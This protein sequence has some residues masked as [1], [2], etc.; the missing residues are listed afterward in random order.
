MG[1]LSGPESWSSRGAYWEIQDTDAESFFSSYGTKAR[2]WEITNDRDERLPDAGEFRTIGTFPSRSREWSSG[3]R[4]CTN[5]LPALQRCWVLVRNFFLLLLQPYYY[6]S[7]CGRRGEYIIYLW[8]AESPHN[9]LIWQCNFQGVQ[10]GFLESC[11]GDTGPLDC[12]I[13]TQ[14]KPLWHF[15]NGSRRNASC[16]FV[17]SFWEHWTSAWTQPT[18]GWRALDNP[19]PRWCQWS[20]SSERWTLGPS[21]ASQT[22]IMYQ[23]RWHVTGWSLSCCCTSSLGNSWGTH[24]Y[25]IKEG[26]VE[27]SRF[28]LDGITA[29]MMMMLIVISGCFC[30]STGSHQWSSKEYTTS[31]SCVKDWSKA[32]SCLLRFSQA[33]SSRDICTRVCRCKQSSIVQTFHL[34]RI[35]RT[36]SACQT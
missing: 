14:S 19:T 28:E 31:C 9:F 18:H 17:S 6:P 1:D 26:K 2:S 32:D 23:Y 27:E 13:G 8:R 34:E 20:G 12:W 35:F 10:C 36:A 16:K 5:T 33:I 21:D 30:H 24:P 3:A 22:C 11:N 7:K 4:L 15:Q 25:C 29:V